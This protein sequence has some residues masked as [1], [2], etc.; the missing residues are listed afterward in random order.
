MRYFALV[1]VALLFLAACTDR[2]QNPPSV[3]DGVSTGAPD[4]ETPAGPPEHRPPKPPGDSDLEPPSGPLGE[5]GYSVLVKAFH[6]RLDADHLAYQL[7][8]KRIN[9]F[10]YQYDGEWRVCVGTY[11]TKGRARR[12][13]R[14]VHEKGFTT[15]R[16]IGP[17]DDSI[18]PPPE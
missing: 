7:R 9:N 11:A 4:S 12:T 3:R 8:M 15:A 13:L 2:G 10:V 18:P 5:Y 6:N 16:V 1:V 14:L 17:G